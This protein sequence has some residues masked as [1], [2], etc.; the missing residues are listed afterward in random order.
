MKVENVD[1][2]DDIRETGKIPRMVIPFILQAGSLMLKRR[3]R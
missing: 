3:L 1:D 2:L